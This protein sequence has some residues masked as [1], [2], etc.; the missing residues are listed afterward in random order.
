M[1]FRHSRTVNSG[2]KYILVA[3]DGFTGRI[4]GKPLKETKANA[5]IT[6]VNDL[7]IAWGRPQKIR[8]DNGTYFV[9]KQFEDFVTEKH[10]S[11]IKSVRYC[12][13][14]NGIAERSVEIK[15]TTTS[16]DQPE[17]SCRV[18]DLVWIRLD[19]KTKN[20]PFKDLITKKDKIIK[21]I[22]KHTVELAE[23]G[24]WSKRN[25]VL[26]QNQGREKKELKNSKPQTMAKIPKDQ[27]YKTP[28][29]LKAALCVLCQECRISFPK[30]EV[31]MTQRLGARQ[32]VCDCLWTGNKWIKCQ[33]CLDDI[34]N[35]RLLV[36]GRH[37]IW[38]WNKTFCDLSSK[39]KIEG[40]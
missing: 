12:P 4:W 39:G 13:Q 10:I 38:S 14:S 19:N 26:V 9:G 27:S 31:I 20:K 21:I 11:L 34:T 29:G 37:K 40:A 25:L 6:A 18:G 7:M 15:R 22:D 23:N 24:I 28:G 1:V 5:I 33:I 32:T 16:K 2:N 36:Y 35:R 8:V 17:D 30:I 3:V